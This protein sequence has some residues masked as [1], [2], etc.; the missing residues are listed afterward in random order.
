MIF[1]NFNPSTHKLDE[2]TEHIEQFGL[3]FKT[4]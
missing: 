2:M 1:V 3:S 4:K